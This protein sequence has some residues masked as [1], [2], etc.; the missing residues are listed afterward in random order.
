MRAL[1]DYTANSEGELTIHEGDVF[2]EIEGGDDDWMMVRRDNG[3]VGCVP[4]SYVSAGFGVG[5]DGGDDA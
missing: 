5:D 1:Y 3:E 2:E 4:R